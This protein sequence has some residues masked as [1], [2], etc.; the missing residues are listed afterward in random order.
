MPGLL[1]GLYIDRAQIGISQVYWV[2]KELRLTKT[3]PQ[4]EQEQSC[5]LLIKLLNLEG[6][7]HDPKRKFFIA[8]QKGLSVVSLPSIKTCSKLSHGTSVSHQR[9][10]IMGT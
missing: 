9:P 10:P 5:Q 2:L 6:R 8:S 4:K 7:K 1:L 3:S